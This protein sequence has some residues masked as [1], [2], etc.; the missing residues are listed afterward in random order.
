MHNTHNVRTDNHSQRLPSHFA[1]FRHNFALQMEAYRERVAATI[2]A[3]AQKH[4][5]SPFDLAHALGT[6]P[7]TT[8]RW[9]RGERT[10]Q[11][12]FRKQLALHWGLPLDTFEPGAEIEG[13]RIH[14][15]LDRIE[16]LLEEVLD[17]LKKLSPPAED[18]DETHRQPEPDERDPVP[19][20]LDA[21]EPS[22]DEEGERHSA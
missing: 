16:E 18:D 17:R 8:E 6:H 2:H 5:E 12:R 1:T 15:Q 7:S 21:V 20:S 11:P 10:P 4:G 19:D 14:G 9:F 22:T 3:E 13:Q